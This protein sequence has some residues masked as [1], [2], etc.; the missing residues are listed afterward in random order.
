MEEQDS[1]PAGREAGPVR[2][3][4]SRGRAGCGTRASSV[5][6]RNGDTAAGQASR[7]TLSLSSCVTLVCT[8]TGWRPPSTPVS[9]SS[10]ETCP[11][12]SPVRGTN[13][14]PGAPGPPWLGLGRRFPGE[15]GS[16]RALTAH[17][18]PTWAQ[19]F[20]AGFILPYSFF[21]FF[22]FSSAGIKSLK[23]AV[24]PISAGNVKP[25]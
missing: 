8:L 17:L 15:S 14:R 6:S 2:W 9:P 11:K 3:E 25:G 21:S 23:I 19:L 10:P 5:S 4:G 7:P 13:P 1:P 18:S 16:G 20:T 12:S 22:F 24:L